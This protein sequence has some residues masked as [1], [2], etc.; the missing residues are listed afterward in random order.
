MAQEFRQEKRTEFQQLTQMTDSTRLLE[1]TKRITSLPLFQLT[2]LPLRNESLGGCL[3]VLLQCKNL[4]ATRIRTTDRFSPSSQV[5]A[6]VTLPSLETLS[7]TF[8]ALVS[9]EVNGIETF[10]A[11]LTLPRLK[12]LHLDLDNEDMWPTAV[13]SDFQVIPNIEEID[14]VF[15]LIDTDALI[16][17]LGHDP[18]LTHNLPHRKLLGVHLILRRTSIR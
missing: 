12:T 3:A 1:T 10:L 7:L 5:L 8:D 9:E 16:A 11:P 14:T 18:P 6:V 4:V 13:F 17:L 2:H 15:S